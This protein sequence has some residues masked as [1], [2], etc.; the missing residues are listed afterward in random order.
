MHRGEPRQALERCGTLG[1]LRTVTSRYGL[2]VA[3]WLAVFLAGFEVLSRLGIGHEPTY[4]FDPKYDRIS[5]PHQPVV[6]SREG[7]SRGRTNELGHHDA[8]MPATL[9]V[10]GVLVVGDSLTEA[11]HVSRADRYT[12][13]LAA[14]S[15]RRIY[16]AGHSGWTPLNALRFI[17]AE[18]GRFAPA[19][20]IVQVS[21][22][23]LGEI[24]MRK[25]T[26]VVEREGVLAIE[27]P[28]RI[29]RGLAAKIT[30]MRLL[31]AN[32]A[33]LGNVTVAGLGLFTSAGGDDAAPKDS[34]C[35]A[36]PALALRAIPWIVGELAR[37]H[38]DVRLLYLPEVD[39]Y[40]GCV[41]RCATSRQLFAD[42]AAAHHVRFIDVTAAVCA[43][44][45]RDGQPLNGF[46]NSRPGVGHFNA[47][48]HVVIARVLADELGAGSR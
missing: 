22:N 17:E 10:D 34:S 46:W 27:L 43:A 4:R 41:D 14:G 33:F 45:A 24:V 5:A 37:A 26:H 2:S 20:V 6:Q 30:Q 39:Y 15:G 19:T 25:R 12:D 40:G 7:Y 38:P 35:G 32:S 29:K 11:Q 21:G 18:V 16:N 42:A 44:Y 47:R 48:G 28:V 23:D 8:P 3:C 31:V 36:P 13:R 9:P 1:Y